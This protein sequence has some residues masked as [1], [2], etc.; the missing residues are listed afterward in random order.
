MSILYVCENL[1]LAAASFWSFP[2]AACKVSPIR[3][4][5]RMAV[6][7]YINKTKKSSSFLVKVFDKMG[8]NFNRSFDL[9]SYKKFFDDLGYGD[10]E[11]LVAEGRMPCAVAVITK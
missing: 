10:A 9:E 11:Y 2:T 4:K 8:A 5:F 7:T 1:I 6:P 3:K